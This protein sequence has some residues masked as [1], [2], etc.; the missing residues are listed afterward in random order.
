MAKI[1]K[2]NNP[3]FINSEMAVGRKAIEIGGFLGFG[4]TKYPLSSVTNFMSEQDV[5]LGKGAA[6][7]LLGAGVGAVAFGGAGAVVGSVVGGNNKKF[8]TRTVSLEFDN[9][10]WIVVEFKDNMADNLVHNA[11]NI[12]LSQIQDSPFAK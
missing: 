4:A 12:L 10:N 8:T 9:N 3:K 6:G 11:L 1:I 2:S 5:A 7:S